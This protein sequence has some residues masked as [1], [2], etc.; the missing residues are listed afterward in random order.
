MIPLVF[1]IAGEP[2]GDL[3][4]ARLMAALRRETGDQIRF[5]GV[6]GENMAAQGLDS[7]FD[8]GDLAVMGF[9]EVL[10]RI[11]RILGRVSQ[12]VAAIRAMQPQVLVTIDSWGFTGRVNKAI[13]QD[14]HIVP[15]I[16]Q[17]H[18]VAPMVWAWKARRVHDLAGRLDHLM[19]LLPHE[20]PYFLAA[21]L[22]TTFVG[23]PVI[24]SEGT[25]GD[26]AAFRT[27][28]GIDAK[29]PLLCFLP[30]SRQGEISRLLP[31]FE[32]TAAQ[33]AVLHPG[34]HIVVPTVA[35]VAA[36]VS[37]A[38]ERWTVPTVVVRSAREKYDAFAAVDAA[39]AAS[40]TVALE[41]A[42][43]GV[44]M[45]VTYRVTAMTAWIFRRLTTVKYVNLI[46]LLLDRLVVPELL[47]EE[48]QPELLTAAMNGLMTD[49]AARAAQKEG[50]REAMAKLGA[51]GVPPSVRAAQVV[52]EMIKSNQVC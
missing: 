30:G 41:L 42:R 47:Q 34:L 33:L 21:G 31:V 5:A 6:G 50:M 23:H 15:R 7:L 48:C 14:R 28:H 11:P 10:P 17:V 22:P 8:L 18:Y 12:T 3:L 36:A 46:N 40:G 4:G 49:P 35:T 32:Q 27:R 19:A 44:P 9:L 16:P 51:G 43:A 13:R 38:V 24:E 52:L 25:Q 45:V 2:S 29:A 37:A 26:G 1:I 39:L 20:P